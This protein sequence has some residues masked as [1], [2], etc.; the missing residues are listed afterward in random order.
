MMAGK[1]G[2]KRQLRKQEQKAESSHLYRQEH[3]RERH[4]MLGE[5]VNAQGCPSSSIAPPP[6]GLTTS[7]DSISNLGVSVQKYPSLWEIS[8]FKPP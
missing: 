6:K 4:W 3:N 8:L 7:P 1:C 5:I 2:S